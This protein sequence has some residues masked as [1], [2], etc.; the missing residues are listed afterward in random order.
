MSEWKKVKLGDCITT[1]KGFAF[2][3]VQYVDKGIP[4]VRVSDFT[5]NSISEKDLVY[6]PISGYDKYFDYILYEKDIL[7]QNSLSRFLHKS[8]T[9][10]SG[11]YD[12]CHTIR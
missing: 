10:Y 6:Y 3:S 11:I 4:V 8:L 7:I 2:K 1:K 12:A 9:P 5:Q